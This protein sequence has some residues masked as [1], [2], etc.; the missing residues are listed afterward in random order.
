MEKLAELIIRIPVVLFALTVHEVAHGWVAY[1]FGDKTA[2]YSGRISLN[3]LAHLD[4]FGTLMLMFGPFG[5]AKPVPV[6]P[7]YFD[8]PR[9]GIFYVSLAGPVSNIILAILCGY[10]MRVINMI[11]PSLSTNNYLFVFLSLSI[12]VN[13]GL[14]FF[15]LIPVP[16]LDG[17]NVLIA[18]LP[19]KYGEIFLRHS[20]TLAQ[21]MLI[22]IVA[23]WV[24]KIPFFSGPLNIFFNPFY[25]L[26]LFF[27]YWG[28]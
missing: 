15:N 7:R 20:N 3:P 16:P 25:K 5:W 27:I 4:L 9:K 22:L 21:I 13:S 24:I 26:I 28:N 17:S 2:Y 18:L 1:K 23:E 6:D 11:F 14:A 10:I 12:M 8:N 19:R